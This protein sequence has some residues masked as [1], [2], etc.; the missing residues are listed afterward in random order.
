M[1][2]RRVPEFFSCPNC[3]A[4]VPVTAKVCRECGSDDRTGWQSS[5]EIDYQ[6]VEIPD[7][8]G[9]DGPVAA[10][11]RRSPWALVVV[12]VLVGALLFWAVWR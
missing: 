9:P 12:L 5:E 8:W 11:A 10:P 2:P 1:S 3:G 4:E 7:G 6:S